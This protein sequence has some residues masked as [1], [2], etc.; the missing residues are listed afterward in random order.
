M[1]GVHSDEE[2]KV[3]IDLPLL[4]F[5][6]PVVPCVIEALTKLIPGKTSTSCISD[7]PI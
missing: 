1:A 3:Q 5:S 7:L 4:A 2:R 6:L